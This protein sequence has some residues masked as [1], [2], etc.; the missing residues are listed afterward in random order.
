ML[1]KFRANVLNVFYQVQ[2]QKT[3]Q[4]KTKTKTKVIG[5]H[6]CLRDVMGQYYPIYAC[7]H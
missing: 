4:N 5:H 6:A 3:K 1:E 7:T 2:F